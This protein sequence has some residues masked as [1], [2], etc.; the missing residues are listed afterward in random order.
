MAMSADSPWTQY[1]WRTL[2]DAL[3]YSATEILRALGEEQSV[4]DLE[5]LRKSNVSKMSRIQNA[6]YQNGTTML[7]NDT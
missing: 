2:L 4:A 7:C 6:A 3:L 1:R 5:R